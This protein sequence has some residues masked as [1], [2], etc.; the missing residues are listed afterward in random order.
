MLIYLNGDYVSEE[1][2]KISIRDRGF[3]IGE[4][5]FEG[6]R[7]YNGRVVDSVLEKHLLRLRRSIRFMELNPDPI[8]ETARAK[9]PEVV[10]RNR[11]EILQAGDV[12]IH[13]IVTGG[14]G[15]EG[16][17]TARPTVVFAPT[18][19]PFKKLFARDIYSEGARLVPSMMTRNPFVS[20]DPRVKSISRLPNTRAERKQMREGSGTWTATFDNNGFVTEATV[21]GIG[22]FEGGILVVPPRW[23]R[24]DS[25][26]MQVACE[27]ATQLGI[28]VEER[29][30]AIYD[31]LNADAVYLFGTSFGMAPVA[32]A[33]GIPLGSDR[34]IG[35]R[36]LAKWV[37]LVGFDFI[38][39]SRRRARGQ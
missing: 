39:Q 36:I 21:A 18:V 35:N 11:E 7:T 8:I 13:T 2:A 15:M 32:E 23:E 6:W 4:G 3:T 1:N 9:W 27:L 24:L 20:A 33:D 14:V 16:F 25:V 34:D 26:S 29:P 31:L 28:R 17:T 37:E 30:L 5:V 22:L 10:E 38:E 12:W 19:I